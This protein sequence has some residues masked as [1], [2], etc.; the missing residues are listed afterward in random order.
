MA[1][2]NN[3]SKAKW[4]GHTGGGNF[5]QKAL[6]LI[7]RIVPLRLIYCLMAFVVPF[8]I[9]FAN[10]RYRA[11]Y[12]Y[13]RNHFAYPPFKA[14]VKT[15]Y[16]HFIFGQI[17]IDR[18]AIFAGKRNVF[19]IEIEN[20]DCFDRLNNNKE[21]FI[22]T[23]AHIGNYEIA[24]YMLKSHNKQFNTLVYASETLTVSQNRVE[25][26]KENN[27]NLIPIC[28]DISHIL[29]A[30]VALQNGEILSAVVDRTN[31]SSKSIECS[32]LNGKADFPV[33]VF[34]LAAT[35]NVEMI[36]VFSVKVSYNKYK[37]FIKHLNPDLTTTMSKQQKAEQLIHSYIAHTEGILKLFPE[38]WFNFYDFWKD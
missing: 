34:M 20:Y 17:V 19:D 22:I 13:F 30:S 4:Q 21:G 28:D 31:D 36:A 14:F 10:K 29:A 15:C 32:F 1:N 3:S 2:N 16:N 33:G 5:G 18:F 25:M 24:G 23:S 6:V 7:L 27:I 11:I 35:F 37:I 38:Q 9:V 26:M 8:Y 12:H